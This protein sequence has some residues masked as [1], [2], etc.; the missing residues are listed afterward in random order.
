VL[1]GTPDAENSLANPTTIAPAEEAV[2]IA[3]GSSAVERAL[4]AHSL[5]I[6]R[7]AVQ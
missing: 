6:L 2:T 1:T 4:P 7:V 5:T 3:A